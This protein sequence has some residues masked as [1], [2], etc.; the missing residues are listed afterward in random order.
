MEQPNLMHRTMLMVLYATGVRRTE[1]S[2]L[3]ADINAWWSI[4]GSVKD[5]ES[6]G[7]FGSGDHRTQI[8]TSCAGGAWRLG[9]PAITWSLQHPSTVVEVKGSYAVYVSQPQALAS[10]IEKAAQNVMLAK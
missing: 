6:R 5:L 3:K 7:R 1:L 8:R 2:L 10:I 9:A 4:F